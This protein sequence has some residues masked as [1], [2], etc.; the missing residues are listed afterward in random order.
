[1][2]R[3]AELPPPPGLEGVHPEPADKGKA[4]V[5][6]LEHYSEG[7]RG[8][9][10]VYLNDDGERVKI[11]KGGRPYRVDNRGFR[12]FHNSPR[13]GKFTPKEWQ[14]IPHENLMPPSRKES[15]KDR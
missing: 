14:R 12:K 10:R 15:L 6:V 4:F 7:A 3:R 2:A 8:D 13:P 1:M 11:D 5:E 9:G